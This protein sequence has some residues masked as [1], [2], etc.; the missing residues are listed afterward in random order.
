MCMV[1]ILKDL[2]IVSEYVFG[3]FNGRRGESESATTRG[4]EFGVLGEGGG[5]TV[6]SVQAGY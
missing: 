1:Y 5:E 4:P 2:E 3:H 6:L